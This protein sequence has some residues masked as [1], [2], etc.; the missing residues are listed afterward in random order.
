MQNEKRG[1]QKKEAR[2]LWRFLRGSAALFAVS[3]LCA[4][5]M[6]LADMITPQIIRVA[7]DNVIGGNPM[8]EG[9]FAARLVARA[10]GAE[11]LHARLWALAAAVVAVAL[12][13]AASQYFFRVTNTTA[14][15][16]FVKTARDALFTH[17]EHLPFSW[18]M[19][20]K[21]GDIIQRC[22]SDIETIKRFI[23][24]QMTNVFRIVILVVLSMGFMFS[25][26]V[27][28]TL[29]VLAPMP[30]I[31]VYS[32]RF[33]R[34]IREGFIE[35]DENFFG[36]NFGKL[37]DEAELANDQ[38][39][40]LRKEFDDL[41]DARQDLWNKV[42]ESYDNLDENFDYANFDEA[43]YI[44]SL[45]TLT[46]DEKDVLLKDL[47]KLDEIANKLTALCGANCG[48]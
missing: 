9:T 3:I 11:Y 14:T 24:E 8:T 19:Q 20:N 31:V 27:P 25:M 28:L 26:N 37:C 18:H 5:L 23:S 7:V 42:Y 44:A 29:I 16:T 33:H 32:I 15:E 17:I 13:K 22:T 48:R 6:A 47:A 10:G 39:Q 36:D 2:L 40:A 38:I 1:Q 45:T 35:C 4:G 21:T 46:A 41:V 34:S 30:L 43:T 12:V